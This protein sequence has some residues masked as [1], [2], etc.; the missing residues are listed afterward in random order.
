MTGEEGKIGLELA[1]KSLE[2]TLWE[3]KPLE[4]PEGLPEIFYREGAAFVTL[5]LKESG[6]L[7]GCIGSLLAHR[8]LAED[9]VKNAVSAATADPRFPTVTKSE[10]EKV[11]LELSVL[12]HPKPFPYETPEELLARITP[13]ED[14]VIIKK[15]PYQATFLPSVWEQIPEK[16]DFFRHLCA[17]AGLP[18][19]FY[20]T[21]ALE[22]YTYRAE[23]FHEEEA[24]G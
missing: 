8:P 20:L 3:G 23:I 6:R 2:S 16:S 9:I 18:G 17:K 15:G 7:R 21:G 19:D 11:T 12:T 13:G 24:H 10:L 1:R 5:N 4:V 14:G 22:V